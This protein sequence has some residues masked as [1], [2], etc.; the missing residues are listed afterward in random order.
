MAH[1]IPAEPDKRFMTDKELLEIRTLSTILR[2]TESLGGSDTHSGY[3]RNKPTH[4]L[5]TQYT[6]LN[7]L[8]QTIN[9]GG[10]EV[11]ALIP[12]KAT[13]QG[14]QLYST[15]SDEP[16]VPVE[17]IHDYD[18]F[19]NRNPQ[20]DEFPP[21]ENANDIVY[22]IEAV[23]GSDS[24]PPNF[25]GDPLACYGR[26]L[27]ENEYKQLDFP[28]IAEMSLTLLKHARN[29]QTRQDKDKSYNDFAQFSICIG[30]RRL[31][32]RFK[33]GNFFG[34]FNEDALARS[35]SEA[36]ADAMLPEQVGGT[37]VFSPEEK[38]H[39][40]LFNDRKI[41][42]KDE[43]PDDVIFNCKGRRLLYNLLRRLLMSLRA[44]IAAALNSQPTKANTETYNQESYQHS[45]CSV[46]SSV[47]D[48][49]ILL[50]VFGQK[51]R[52]TLEWVAT[53]CKLEHSTI[54]AKYSHHRLKGW[55]ETSAFTPVPRVELTSPRTTDGHQQPARLDTSVRA[56]SPRL[57]TSPTDDPS[58]L[59]PSSIHVAANDSD[60]E[61]LLSPLPTSSP[62]DEE[63]SD[64]LPSLQ[65]A[66]A[67]HDDEALQE[68][69]ADFESI[70]EAED[71]SYITQNPVTGWWDACYRYLELVCK[72]I[73][74]VQKVHPHT[75]RQKT[76]SFKRVLDR[77]LPLLRVR[78]IEVKPSFRDLKIENPDSVLEEMVATGAILP[79]H[80]SAL[81]NWIYENT[82]KGLES[83]K[84][85]GKVWESGKPHIP[86]VETWDKLKF[87][88]TMHCETILLT[89]HVLT[90]DGVMGPKA[91]TPKQISDLLWT[92]NI[93]VSADLVAQLKDISDIL[94]VSKKCCPACDAIVQEVR[95]L[96]PSPIVYPGYHTTWFP[97]ALP[98]WTP[99]IIGAPL[100]TKLRAEVVH[101]GTKAFNASVNRERER[102]PT[103]SNASHDGGDADRENSDSKENSAG[104]EDDDD[105]DDDEA[106]QAHSR[107][108][109]QAE[110]SWRALPIIGTSTPR[111]PSPEKRPHHSDSDPSPSTV[112][113]SPSKLPRISKDDRQK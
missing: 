19:L 33:L 56:Q 103:P 39:L 57:L 45:I 20:Q 28:F 49:A 18:L 102:Q 37:H 101:R 50:Q 40:G 27:K 82:P 63:K 31:N 44:A 85:E 64:P 97:I 7:N 68:E 62:L 110:Q 2:W 104:K 93:T 3:H 58:S 26:L 91:P 61:D 78:P 53:V 13:S 105:D 66:Q 108:S 71:L 86:D 83:L 79:W 29:A 81:R 109:S 113:A 94:A 36:D 34:V 80:S 54:K 5:H 92:H 41:I 51:L 107:V 95:A 77:V 6:L 100:L 84:R 90:L 8:L 15:T 10:N 96:Q 88:G 99:R 12:S 1:Q 112:M 17:S 70:T 111:L 98:P 24:V 59:S 11:S 16:V 30:L 48:V 35:A 69:D 67:Q 22:T 4:R 65:N 72:H 42:S 43:I 25:A 21:S 47:E 89:I 23:D 55:T 14:I 75:G 52:L 74:G 106:L 46:V 60:R 87:S 76:K 38:A 73:E 32:A 9:R